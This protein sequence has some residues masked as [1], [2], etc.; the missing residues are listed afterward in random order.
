MSGLTSINVPVIETGCK[1]L[2]L[3][4]PPICHSGY[5]EVCKLDDVVVG[6]AL[7]LTNIQG[8]IMKVKREIVKQGKSRTG[9]ENLRRFLESVPQGNRVALEYL[10]YRYDQ[11]CR[12]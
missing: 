7:H 2:F 5:S 10:H 1:G 9:K 3:D 12:I 8:T 6:L 4:E 11:D